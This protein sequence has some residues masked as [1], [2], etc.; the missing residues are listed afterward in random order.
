MT[1]TPA[2]VSNLALY[3]AGACSFSRAGFRS[4]AAGLSGAVCAGTATGTANAASAIAATAN[5][6]F[7]M[8]N[9]RPGQP[10]SR[11]LCERLA[12][13]NLNFPLRYIQRAFTGK[14]GFAAHTHAGNL[15]PFDA[16]RDV[17]EAA[18][19]HLH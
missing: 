1:N 6:R 16:D 11:Q 2:L 5:E 8:I 17:D 14:H 3:V 10:D 7:I 13:C 4:F 19:A 9:L 12:F 15:I 18:A